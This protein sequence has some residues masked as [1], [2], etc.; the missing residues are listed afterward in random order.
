VSQ[1]LRRF[2]SLAKRDDLLTLREPVNAGTLTLPVGSAYPLN[3]GG[4]AIRQAGSGRA[5]GIV[6]VT[7][8][9]P[10]RDWKTVAAE[11]SG[12]SGSG[13]RT[14]V[15]DPLRSL[16]GDL[17]DGVVVAVVV[18][19]RDSVPFGDGGDQEVGE[20]DGSHPTGCPQL[21]LDLE[22]SPPVDIF[23]G[24]PFVAHRPVGVDG[25]VLLGC[26]RR[27]EDLELDHRAGGD[28][29]C[30]DERREN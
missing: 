24:Q 1:K 11:P 30:F 18:Q 23:G 6:V 8:L 13:D 20:G 7:V 17:V 22:C 26:A 4:A 9:I 10:G 28:D 14:S 12:D 15:D 27:P 16:P 2:L 25:F 5:R 21:P 3:V 29:A 19:N